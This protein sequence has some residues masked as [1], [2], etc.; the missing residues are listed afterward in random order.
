MNHFGHDMKNS[1]FR[2]WVRELWYAN[3]DEHADLDQP[4]YTHAEYF[5]NFK[6]WLK[7]EYRHQRNKNAIQ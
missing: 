2:T 7:R 4:K 3:C 1:A 6:W 5:Q